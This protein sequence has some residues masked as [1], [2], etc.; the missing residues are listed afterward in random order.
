MISRQT[1][2]RQLTT[3]FLLLATTAL[4]S[5]QRTATAKVIGT[6][7]VGTFPV[8]VTSNAKTHKTYVANNVSSSVTVID[9][10]TEYAHER[11]EYG[12]G[13]RKCYRGESCDQ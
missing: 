5:G 10:R 12:R 13:G 1:L 8:A 11:A 4:A 9:E 3:L 2:S 7:P 6:V